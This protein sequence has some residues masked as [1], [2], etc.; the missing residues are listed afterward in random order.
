MVSV[1]INI[2]YCL[3][4]TLNKLLHARVSKTIPEVANSFNIL[5][6]IK[7]VPFCGKN[8]NKVKKDGT[9]KEELLEKNYLSWIHKRSGWE[10]IASIAEDMQHIGIVRSG[11]K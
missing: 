6:R 3:F 1:T 5:I 7:Q 8:R 10:N 11:R 2:K 9:T 4:E